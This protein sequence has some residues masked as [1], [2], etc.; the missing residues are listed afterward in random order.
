[1]NPICSKSFYT[2]TYFLENTSRGDECI[3]FDPRF[4]RPGSKDMHYTVVKH[5]YKYCFKTSSLFGPECAL[6]L[7]ILNIIWAYIFH[8]VNYPV[9][10]QS[11]DKPK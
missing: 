11:Y 2:L 4:F 6:D 5:S 9:F 10:I 1:M 7:E 8:P 3:S